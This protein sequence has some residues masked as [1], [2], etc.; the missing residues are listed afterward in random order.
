MYQGWVVIITLARKAI[1]VLLLLLRSVVVLHYIL[2]HHVDFHILPA[3][4]EDL[5]LLLCVLKNSVTILLVGCANTSEI[6]P[7]FFPLSPYTYTP[8]NWD[9]PDD[10]LSRS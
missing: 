8:Q 6:D 7:N 9:S 3:Y 4:I 5:S 2:S 10:I 1:L